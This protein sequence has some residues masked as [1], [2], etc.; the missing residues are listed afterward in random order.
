MVEIPEIILALHPNSKLLQDLQVGQR[1]KRS[2]NSCYLSLFV[3]IRE[4]TKVFSFIS[5]P[6]IPA[7]GL[8]GLLW[9]NG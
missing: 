4:N 5:I 3:F 8:V 1:A 2:H 7:S 9:F 6:C